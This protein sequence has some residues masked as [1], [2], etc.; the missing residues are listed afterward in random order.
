M[1]GLAKYDG[2]LW[3]AGKWPASVSCTFELEDGSE[4]KVNEKKIDSAAA[5]FI[6]MVKRGH[7]VHLVKAYNPLSKDDDKIP[8]HYYKIDFAEEYLDL[9][10]QLEEL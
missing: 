3:P 2:K 7:Y 1:K 5:T 10:K 4:V 9:L 6:R 8:E